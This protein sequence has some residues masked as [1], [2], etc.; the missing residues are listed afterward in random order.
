MCDSLFK[1]YWPSMLT[2]V[3]HL[4]FSFL[5]FLLE[6]RSFLFI[7]KHLSHGH[8]PST[9]TSAQWPKSITYPGE[10]IFKS[11][12]SLK[13]FQSDFILSTNR[14]L[15]WQKHIL[16]LKKKGSEMPEEITLL[17][18]KGKE[19]SW[20]SHFK[21]QQQLYSSLMHYMY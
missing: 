4:I 18:N 7:H 9:K 17:R 5:W 16:F 1:L 11:V 20:I 2:P 6:G 8:P 3:F 19:K 15:E 10:P 13:W 21:I 14:I 12:A